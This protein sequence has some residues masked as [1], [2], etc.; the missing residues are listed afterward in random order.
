MQLSQFGLVRKEGG[1][2]IA[3]ETEESIFEALGISN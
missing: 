3:G 2:R 1:E